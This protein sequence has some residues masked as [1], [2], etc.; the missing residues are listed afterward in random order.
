MSAW[1][2]TL[3][4]LIVATGVV[5][6]SQQNGSKRNDLSGAESYRVYCA[7]CHGSDGKGDGPAAPALKKAPSD[8]TQI[9]KRNHGE[10]PAFRITHI[11]DGYEIESVHGSRDMPI[12]GDYF[13]DKLLLELREHNLTEY[14]R[15]I[16]K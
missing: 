12:W 3:P 14:I 8:L 13:R 11:I 16:Q 1:N 9:S 15:S 6:M 4:I 10:F 5:A 2:V 7:S